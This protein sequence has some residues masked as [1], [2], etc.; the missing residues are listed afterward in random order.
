MLRQVPSLRYLLGLEK[1]VFCLV[2]NCYFP[3]LTLQYMVTDFTQY[4]LPIN[5]IIAK[6]KYAAA[7][8]M[9]KDRSP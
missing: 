9:T 5:I 3:R 7:I 2:I 6:N 8:T 1:E 4:V